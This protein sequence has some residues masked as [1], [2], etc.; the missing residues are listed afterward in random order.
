MQ[1]NVYPTTCGILQVSD[2]RLT[3]DDKL[4]LEISRQ[5]P[6]PTKVRDLRPNHQAKYVKR[7]EIRRLNPDDYSVVDGH[8]LRTEIAGDYMQRVTS[9]DED[10]SRRRRGEPPPPSLLSI[11]VDASLSGD[12]NTP[13]NTTPES[14]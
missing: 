5:C 4:V 2:E 3:Y 11:S 8:L 10:E 12:P 14:Y 1:T 9:Y 6:R 7:L 13:K